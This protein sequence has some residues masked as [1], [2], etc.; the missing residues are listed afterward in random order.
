MDIVKEIAEGCL[1]SS[2]SRF[3]KVL[4]S[5]RSHRR[6]VLESENKKRTIFI[7][8]K[9]IK[10]AQR[11]LLDNFL[12]KLKTHECCFSYSAGQS[13]VKMSAHHLG[14]THFLHLDIR[15]Y[16]D[17]MDW[18]IFQNVIKENYKNTK[19][20][21]CLFSSDADVKGMKSILM[22]R[23][24][25]RQGS[26]TAPYVSNIYLVEFDRKMEL[27]VKSTVKDGKY[28]RYS[29]DIV[30]SSSKRID[31]SII[32]FVKEELANYKLKL[33]YKKIKFYNIKSSVNVVGISM[34]NDYRM[35]APTSI[36]KTIK[37]MVYLLLEKN[38]PTNYNVLYGYIYY[39]LMCDPMYFNFLQEKYMKNNL[40]MLDRIKEKE[41]ASKNIYDYKQ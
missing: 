19:L 37:N 12:S 10:M 15:H 31:E 34:T 7:P 32:D 2:R 14:N 5:A 33:N 3:N 20:Y 9:T 16:F 38:R 4:S 30:I 27:F 8:C 23:G 18:T 1:L 39:L 40:L 11:Y 26:V 17:N 21:N 6:V 28:S 35:T 24:R 25:F 22:F 41:K 36:K 13:T 29:D